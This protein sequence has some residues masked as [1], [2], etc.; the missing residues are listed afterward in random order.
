MR[1]VIFTNAGIGL[2]KFRKELVEDLCR[3]N[4]VYVVLPNDEFIE[5]LKAVGGSRLVDVR[6]DVWIGN[7]VG[8]IIESGTI[9]L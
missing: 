2:Y 1:I 9:M 6:L 8:G 7:G 5:P 3:E 4:E